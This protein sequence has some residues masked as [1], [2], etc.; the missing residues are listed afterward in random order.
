MHNAVH[1]VGELVAQ[2]VELVNDHYQPWRRVVQSVDVLRMRLRD[3]PLPALQLNVQC[4]Q[5]AYRMLQ[6]KIAYAAYAVRKPFKRPERRAA[7]E[8][9]EHELQTIRRIACGQSKAPAL[10]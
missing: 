1:H 4:V 10:Q 7:F 2:R 6:I 8:V 5:R 3:N 9:K